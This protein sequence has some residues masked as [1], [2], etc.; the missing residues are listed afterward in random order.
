MLNKKI[1]IYPITSRGIDISLNPYIGNL[2]N[3]LESNYSIVNK[4]NPSKS[5]I[6]Q[7]IKYL[8]KSDIFFFNWVENLPDK[9]G[10]TFQTILL[11][12]LICIMKLLGKKVIW[13]MHNKISH[14]KQ[15]YFLK[16]QIFKLLIRNANLI[17]THSSEGVT[18]AKTFEF[19]K[20]IPIKY[21]PHPIGSISV[22]SATEQTKIYDFV[23]W[24]AMIPY[25][26]IH[27]FL[28]YLIDSKI[29]NN[30]HILII[31]KFS[32]ADYYNQVVNLAGTHTVVEDRFASMA[33]LNVLINKS[34]FVL[35]TYSNNSVLSSGALMD[36]VGFCAN[37]IGPNT[38]AFSDLNANGI[39]QTYNSFSD[40]IKM[41]KEF[42]KQSIDTDKRLNFI[43]EN[44]W[45]TFGNNLNINIKNL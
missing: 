28:E 1:Y 19:K 4:N 12:M 33:E 34:R 8:R 30:Y 15:N 45:N 20:N 5:G 36:T 22:L 38:G 35:F 43:K 27:S 13:T 2:I 41:H 40:I 16:K 18:Y 7:I 23:I 24:G 44:N 11:F 10:G 21:L 31:G 14:S 39:I 26:G 37:I 29:E 9:K 25:K 3:C 6:F 42:D 17:L 32:S